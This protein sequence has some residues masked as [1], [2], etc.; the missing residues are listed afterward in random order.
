MGYGS[1]KYIGANPIDDKINFFVELA[2]RQH[3]KEIIDLGCGT[4]LLSYELAKRGYRVTGIE[5]AAGMIGQAKQK[6]GNAVQWIVGGYEKLDTAMHSDM[7]IM[8]GQVAQFFLEDNEWDEA[9][10]AIHEVAKPD[11]YLV[12]ESRNPLVRP[13]ANWPDS[14][15]HDKIAN[16]PRGPV[17]WRAENLIYV[18][19]RLR[20][21]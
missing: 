20:Y 15:N 21:I 12:F 6:Y 2:S 11:G 10:R 16:T 18:C 1:V 9:L 4:G 14:D 5:P 19:G 8:T 3:A 7:T 17:E 13:F